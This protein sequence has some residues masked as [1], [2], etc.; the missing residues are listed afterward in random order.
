VL[1]IEDMVLTNPLD[2][3]DIIMVS[4]ALNALLW[5]IGHCICV[6]LCIYICLICIGYC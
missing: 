4:R 1:Y 2:D 5:L 6:Y 3:V